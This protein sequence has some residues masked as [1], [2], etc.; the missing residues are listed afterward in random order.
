MHVVH[1]VAG[2]VVTHAREVLVVLESRAAAPALRTGA[3]AASATGRPL[4]GSASRGADAR[5]RS[6][7]VPA[8]GRTGRTA[9]H[10]R[11]PARTRRGVAGT[12]GTAARPPRRGSPASADDVRGTP[13]AR[14]RRPG[15]ALRQADRDPTSAWPRLGV[16]HADHQERRLADERAGRFER[17]V[18]RH[19]PPRRGRPPRGAAGDRDDPR[20]PQQRRRPAPR[21]REERREHRDADR[22][23]AGCG[24]SVSAL[25]ELRR[26]RHGA[27]H[28]AEDSSAVRSRM[29]ASVVGTNRCPSTGSARS[30]TSSGRT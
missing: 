6:R 17:C 15:R 29:R 30:F 21:G 23:P 20:R 18:D 22:D 26:D 7:A 4:A 27:E 13:S 19:A 14:D 3:I 8:P 2:F 10:P 16:L 5:L 11:G 24:V 25:P 9:R 1:R 12:R 28:L